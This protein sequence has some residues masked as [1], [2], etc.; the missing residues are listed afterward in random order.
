MSNLFKCNGCGGTYSDSQLDGTL[1]FHACPPLPPDENA[2]VAERP[3][4]RDENIVPG[5]EYTTTKDG[6]RL[7]FTG[8]ASAAMRKGTLVGIQLEGAGTKCMSDATL[9][10]PAWITVLKRRIAKEEN[11]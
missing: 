10:E 2:V 3:N 11:A 7:L 5:I 4:K 6:V 8:A 1:Y 9:S